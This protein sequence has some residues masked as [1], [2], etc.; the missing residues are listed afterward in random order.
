M[1]TKS[2]SSLLS[3]LQQQKNR[4]EQA[5]QNADTPTTVTPKR[6]PQKSNKPKENAASDKQ[7]VTDRLLGKRSSSSSAESTEQNPEKKPKLNA[8]A[9]FRAATQK[10]QQGEHRDQS[11]DRKSDRHENGRSSERAPRKREREESNDSRP[12]RRSSN[13]N[14]SLDQPRSSSS[15]RSSSSS[16]PS[17]SSSRKP[18]QRSTDNDAADANIDDATPQFK[19]NPFVYFDIE[20]GNRKCGR[21]TIEL[22]AN[23]APKTAENFRALCT[24]EKGNGSAGKPLHFK[25]NIFHR[26]VPGFLIQAGDITA[27][28]GTGGD[29]IYGGQ[30][31]DENFEY[32]HLRAGTVAM[33]NIGPDTNTSQFYIT[34]HQRRMAW[35]DKKHVVFGRVI[36]GM[37]VVREI[38]KQ[39]S[40]DGTPKAVVKIAD[41]G[42]IKKESKKSGEEENNEEETAKE[43]EEKKQTE[44]EEP[45]APRQQC[46]TCNGPMRYVKRIVK[47]SKL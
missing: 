3:K 44:T 24:G 42:R 34:T 13:N 35:L 31:E 10:Q 39:G 38:E 4:S 43:E 5:Q 19:K 47:K 45:K 33:A 11:T 41:C 36:R 27:Q 26:I 16:R 18:R 46:P 6:H 23:I 7:Q 30:F 37:Q 20:I 25:N 2:K 17:S 28:D 9:H 22:F 15:N 1:S 14:R 40:E 8:T 32:R 29:S 21:I 12:F